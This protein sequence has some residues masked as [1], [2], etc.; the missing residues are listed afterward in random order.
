MKKIMLLSVVALLTI[1]LN[2]N[3]VEP[4]AKAEANTE[5]NT[6]SNQLKGFV[7]D[8]KTNESLAGA[9]ITANGQKVYT[10]LDGNF[11]ISNVCTGKCTLKISMI[12]YEDQTIEV[13]TN[14]QTPLQVK[15]SQR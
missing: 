8:K 9:T 5:V 10:D 14:E 15:L 3:A 4:A 1:T 11:T 7:L 12:S 6:I 2:V 13:N